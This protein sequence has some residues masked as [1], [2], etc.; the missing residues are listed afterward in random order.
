VN[1]EY[2]RMKEEVILSKTRDGYFAQLGEKIIPIDSIVFDLYS[3]SRGVDG[4]SINI[5]ARR[6]FTT[7]ETITAEVREFLENTEHRQLFIS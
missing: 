5:I 2:P 4:S 6:Y 1:F 7:R 3:F